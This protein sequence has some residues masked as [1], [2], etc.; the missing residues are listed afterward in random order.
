VGA[1]ERPGEWV[2]EPGRPKGHTT[3][4]TRSRYANRVQSLR[5]VE[6]YL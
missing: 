6:R 2:T 1:P 5:I 3:A 4:R